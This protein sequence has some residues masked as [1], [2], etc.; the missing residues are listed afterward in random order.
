MKILAVDYGD[1]RTGLAIC[2]ES[3]LLATPLPQLNEQSMNKVVA[4]IAQ[5]AAEQKAARILI[6]LPMNMDGTEGARAGK[7]RRLAGKVEEAAGLPVVLWDERRTTVT[8]AGILSENGVFG[9]KRKDRLDSVS[10][11]VILEGYLAWRKHHP[12]D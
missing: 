7:S 5:A 6:G 2:D 11:A 9:Q 10:A 12:E 1:A 3:E 8:A 4:L